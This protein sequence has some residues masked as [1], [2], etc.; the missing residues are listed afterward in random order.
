MRMSTNQT[1]GSSDRMAFECYRICTK[2]IV[3]D[4]YHLDC[5]LN[6]IT[7]MAH[8]TSRRAHALQFDAQEQER[9]TEQQHA[10]RSAHG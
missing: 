2:Q 7:S 1:R 9:G 3:L 6:R 4:A 8:V 10:R 5:E